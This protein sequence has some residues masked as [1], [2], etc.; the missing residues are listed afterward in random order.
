MAVTCLQR[1]GV[2]VAGAVVAEEQR[3]VVRVETEPETKHSSMA[4]S[5]Q[6]DHELRFT[7]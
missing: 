4:E 1:E 7:P 3:R 6:I 5:L 2:D